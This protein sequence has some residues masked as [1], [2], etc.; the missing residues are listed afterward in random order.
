MQCG[1]AMLG[2]KLGGRK[3]LTQLLPRPLG[4]TQGSSNWHPRPG[5]RLPRNLAFN[6]DPATHMCVHTYTGTC[7]CT[8]VNTH[9]HPH[10]CA[11]LHTHTDSSYIPGRFTPSLQA[12]AHP[13]PFS[14]PSCKAPALP[15]LP[16]VP[17]SK[18][19]FL[20]APH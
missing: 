3:L 4:A 20:N 19:S 14:H 2:P 6:T 11:H 1:S 8:H 9:T 12:F 15:E 10:I 18:K 13:G 16:Q 17:F 7:T 5:S